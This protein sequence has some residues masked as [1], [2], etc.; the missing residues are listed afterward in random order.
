M[1]ELL[2]KLRHWAIKKLGGYTEQHVHL[3]RNDYH[4][5]DINPINIISD[6]RIDTH[7]IASNM[8]NEKICYEEAKYRLARDLASC[9][10]RNGLFRIVCHEEVES[11]TRIYRA[12]M[13][14]VPPHEEALLSINE[15]GKTS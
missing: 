12:S 10:A 2:L 6:V 5:T 4:V 13:L 1:R 15:G 11:L 8:G 14:I 9:I 3:S 7:F